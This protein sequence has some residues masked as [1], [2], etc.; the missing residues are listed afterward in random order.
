MPYHFEQVKILL[1]EDNRP[2]LNLVKSLLESFGVGT[3]VTALDGEEAFNKFCSI[4]PDI[5][6]TDWMMAPCDGI[7]LARKI[8]NDPKSPNQFVPVILMT[9][10]SEKHRVID[11]RD[12]GITEFIVKPFNARD[13]YKRLYQIIE[14]PR[15]FV[16]CEA[17][18]GPDRRRKTSE[19]YSGPFRRQGEENPRS[20]DYVSDPIDDID[21]R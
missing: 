2:M 17:F 6:I 4:N 1:V 21:F 7:T 16:R 15:K 19:E 3:V 14:K 11:A 8:R 20:E 5:V 12:T 13:L 10:F 18:F 9:G